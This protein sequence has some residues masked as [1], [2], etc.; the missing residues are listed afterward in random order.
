MDTK[1]QRRET[2]CTKCAQGQYYREC[3]NTQTGI[4]NTNGL[5]LEETKILTIQ[6]TITN[7]L[8]KI[9]AIYK[10]QFSINQFNN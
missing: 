4:E 8:I 6:L 9:A 7:I 2:V 5:D 3:T 1:K 10:P